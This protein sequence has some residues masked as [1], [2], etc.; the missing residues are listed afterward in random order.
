MVRPV[1]RALFGSELEQRRRDGA[2]LIISE[3]VSARASY[4]VVN[5]SYS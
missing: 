5:G 1:G 4:A 3:V 2:L